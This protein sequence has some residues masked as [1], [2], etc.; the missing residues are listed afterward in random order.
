MQENG[1]EFCSIAFRVS[2]AYN[3]NSIICIVFFLERKISLS[4]KRTPTSKSH[5]DLKFDIILDKC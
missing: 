5:T 3:M 2:I 4:L 1:T